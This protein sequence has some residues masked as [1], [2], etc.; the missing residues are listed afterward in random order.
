MKKK[1]IAL[2]F[3]LVLF[4]FTTIGILFIGYT[5]PIIK[6]S[7]EDYNIENKINEKPD[8]SIYPRYRYIYRSRCF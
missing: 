1:S 3:N 6:A 8:R 5:Q 7:A 4:A 2:I